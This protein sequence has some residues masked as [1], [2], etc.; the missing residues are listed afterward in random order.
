MNDNG[1][2]AANIIKTL[3]GTT[4]SL[5]LKTLYLQHELVCYLYKTTQRKKSS[6]KFNRPRN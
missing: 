6:R 3:L 4:S 2:C 5:L 1:F